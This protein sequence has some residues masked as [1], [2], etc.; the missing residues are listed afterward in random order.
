MQTVTSKL[1]AKSGAGS[2]ATWGNCRIRIQLRPVR[3]RNTGF[4]YIQLYKFFITLDV[5][6]LFVGYSYYVALNVVH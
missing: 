4:Y 1:M 3:V 2:R 5:N 6:T